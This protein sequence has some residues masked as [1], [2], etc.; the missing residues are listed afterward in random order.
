MAEDSK[1]N[2]IKVN[3][4]FEASRVLIVDDNPT[5]RMLVKAILNKMGIKNIQEAK[6]G[7]DA[8][9]MLQNAMNLAKQFDLVILDW[10]MP[11]KTG[12]DFLKEIR[13]QKDTKKLGVIMATSVSDADKVRESLRVGV[14]DFIIKPI[15]HQ[16]LAEKVEK[17]LVSQGKI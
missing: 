17:F 15:Q 3:P 13:S 4:A 10:N 6:S 11:G 1:I 14:E 5:D 12:I 2:E 7:N 16:L 9:F 8:A